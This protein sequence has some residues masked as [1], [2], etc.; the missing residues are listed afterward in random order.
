MNES[1]LKVDDIC[2]YLKVS[3]ETVYKRIEQRAILGHRVGRCWI[4]KQHEVDEWVRSSG[5]A[6]KSCK[7]VTKQ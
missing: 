4:F 1:W 3:N 2:K 5:V 7:P 6:Y